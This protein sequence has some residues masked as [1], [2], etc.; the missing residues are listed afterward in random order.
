MTPDL[1]NL[2]VARFVLEARSAFA[3]ASGLSDGSF[4]ALVVRDMNNLPAIAGSTLAGVLRHLYQQH[5][6]NE[7]A[8]DHLFG[9]IEPYKKQE[10]KPSRLQ[11]S[12]GCV[13]DSHDQPVEGICETIHDDELL[14]R[15]AQDHP[16]HRE[17]VRLNERGAADSQA[18]YDM[19]VMPAGCRFSFEIMLWSAGGDVTEKPDAETEEIEETDSPEQEWEKLLA[20]LNQFPIGCKS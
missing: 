14:T 2:R 16:M 19:T 1:S 6:A 10:G 9:Y 7:A 13:H 3:I 15:L 11:V 20:L 5:Y 8:T 12:W 4:D 18:K 17:R